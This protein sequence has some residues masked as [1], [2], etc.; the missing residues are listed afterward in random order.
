M[1]RPLMRIGQEFVHPDTKERWRVTDVG[2]RT[3]IAINLD[4]PLTNFDPSWFDGP[5]YAVAEEVWDEADWFT[6]EDVE[7]IEWTDT[8]GKTT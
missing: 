2:T 5:P 1:K 3:F 4:R 8:T 6:L 7:G